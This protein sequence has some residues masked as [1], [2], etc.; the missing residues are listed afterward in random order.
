MA[1]EERA[2]DQDL[3]ERVWRHRGGRR[4]HLNPTTALVLVLAS[5]A[6]VGLVLLLPLS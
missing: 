2:I 5:A 1:S 6:V 3:L 4:P